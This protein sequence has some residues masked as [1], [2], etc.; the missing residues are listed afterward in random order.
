MNTENRRNLQDTP[1]ASR[2]GS[3]TIVKKRLQ[4]SRLDDTV[5]S[6]G[7]SDAINLSETDSNSL[8]AGINGVV[9]D[10]DLEYFCSKIMETADKSEVVD[11]VVNVLLNFSKTQTASILMDAE[12]QRQKMELQED[13]FAEV[14]AK[15]KVNP[16]I[17]ETQSSKDST[18][19]EEQIKA[20]DKIDRDT[21][22]RYQKLMIQKMELDKVIEK[23]QEDIEY[24]RTNVSGYKTKGEELEQY[25]NF[26]KERHSACK[27]ACKRL[28]ANTD[29]IIIAMQRDGA[30][31]AKDMETTKKMSELRLKG[32]QSQIKIFE[33]K[34]VGLTEMLQEILAKNEG[35]SSDE[36]RNGDA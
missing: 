6:N 17:V 18:V 15:M 9:K 33:N 13:A 19:T 25:I 28:K 22:E 31:W 16:N 7:T 4:F 23:Y 12:I 32:L 5:S 11:Q 14:L 8:Q 2:D 21:K 20:L 3:R 34:I 27:L 26:L 35:N 29:D 24:C 1:L 30:E 10:R 36:E